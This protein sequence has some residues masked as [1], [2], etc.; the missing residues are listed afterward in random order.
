MVPRTEV[1]MAEPSRIARNAAATLKGIDSVR[2]YSVDEPTAPRVLSAEYRTV[3]EAAIEVMNTGSRLVLL[4]WPPHPVCLPAIAGLLALGDVAAAPQKCLALEPGWID[5]VADAPIGLRAVLYPYARTAHGPSRQIQIDRRQMAFLQMRHVLRGVHCDDDKALKDYH[6]VLSRVGA[7]SGKGRDGRTYAEYEHPILD[8]II[9]HGSPKEGCPENGQLLWRTKSKTDLGK[10]TRNGSA[11]RPGEA[12][13][14][15]FEIEA[16]RSAQ[17]LPSLRGAPD[18][19]LLDLSK[20]AR[21]RMG[22]DW[23]ST[24]RKAADAFQKA[25]PATGI[26]AVTEDPW[27]CDAARFE[28]LGSRVPKGARKSKPAPS[29]AIFSPTG[30]IL[31][32]SAAVTEVQFVGAAHI[33]ADAFSGQL[34]GSISRLRSIAQKLQDRGNRIAAEAARNIITKIRRCVCLPGSLAELSEYLERETSDVTAADNMAAYRITRDLAVLDDPRQG[35]TQIASD[36]LA[37]VRAEANRLVKASETSTP[38]ASLLEETVSPAMRSSSRTILVLRN[39]MIADFTID[40]LCRKFDKLDGRLE[41][42]IIRLTT[43][44]GL[45]DLAAFTS[46]FRNQFKRAIIVAPTRQSALELLSEPWLPDEVTFLADS[47]TMRFAARDAARLASQIDPPQLK[48]RLE[49]FSFAANARVEQIGAHV[50]ALDTAVEPAEDIDFPDG[51]IIDLAGPQRGDRRLIE[52]TMQSGQQILARP[53]TGL[54]QRDNSY[55]VP[56]FVEIAANNVG[57]GDEICVIGP[58]FIERARSLLNITAAAAEEIRDYHDLVRKRFAELPE[59]NPTARLRLLCKKMGEPAVQTGT[60]RYWIDLDGEAEKSLHEIVAH[61]PQDRD[62]F[63]RFTQTLGIGPVM[64][65]RFWAWAVIAQRSS[66]VRA[67]A[68]FHDA[69]KGILTDRHS[70]LAANKNRAAEIRALRA[71]AD[72]YVSV[73]TAT[74][75]LGK[76]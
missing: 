59:P 66:R 72:E 16:D 48:S 65:A 64:A 7:M 3:I 31:S 21:N 29:R 36:E 25:Y 75:T 20:A 28:V 74:K 17:E 23:I 26:L 2:L 6:T 69:Y 38:M 55:S 60:A 70:A 19:F 42:D 14:F 44:Q 24:A 51:S 56:R 58:R 34:E 27:S 35:A 11:D 18:L 40:R 61:A 71:A 15:L 5:T 76:A 37:D 47:D 22:R 49:R 1:V 54:V 12:R 57:V 33:H 67:G 43:R 41:S 73:V 10:F 13:F 9:P 50:V 68:A 30:A 4:C 32:E 62:T 39:E 45:A 52:L 63:M 46:S 53:R 8:E